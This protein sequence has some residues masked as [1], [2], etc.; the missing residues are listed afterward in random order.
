MKIFPPAVIG[1]GLGVFA[2]AVMVGAV[3]ALGP[4]A[5]P[6]NGITVSVDTVR[7]SLHLM[8]LGWPIAAVLG[9]LSGVVVGL[10]HT[11]A[12]AHSVGKPTTFGNTKPERDRRNAL[13][14]PI[15]RQRRPSRTNSVNQPA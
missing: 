11:E 12:A 13:A 9:G 3:A 1:A 15:E 4:A 5:I 14:T 6:A 2:L 7:T 10:I 8:I